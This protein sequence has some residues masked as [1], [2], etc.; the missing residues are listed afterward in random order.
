MTRK[1]RL[2]LLALA[3]LLVAMI[4]LVV[5]GLLAAKPLARSAV[6]KGAR[7]LGVEVN[8][9]YVDVG[10]GWVRLRE[11]DLALEGVPGL[12]ATIE[13]ATVDLDG[14]TP[15][16]VEARGVSVSM[17]GSAADFVVNLG[18]WAKRHPDAVKFPLVADSVSAV[19]RENAS[20]DPWLT[21]GGALVAPL[22]GG[23]RLTAE[24]ATVLGVSVGP[25]GAMWAADNAAVTFGFGNP[26]PAT[27]L[28]RMDVDRATGTAKVS[29]RPVKLSALAQ[30]LGVRLPIDGN[31][32]VEG[33]ATLS[34]D[35]PKGTTE[36][37]GTLQ[38][39][40]RGY[41]PPHPRELDGIVFGDV[42]TF[43]T[44]FRI[45]GDRKTV[46]LA[47]SRVAAGAFV[48]NG[49]GTT[50]RAE[51]HAKI[52]MNMAGDIP[53]TSLAKSAAVSRLGGALGQ[54]LGD[55]AK[56]TL[57][58]AVRVGVKIEADSRKLDEAKVTHD[59]SIGCTLRFP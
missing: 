6:V 45:S 57:A 26:D 13:R 53:C 30:P 54:L 24:L 19:W 22:P 31:V 11:T 40:L 1:K 44:A 28:V 39:K 55:A 17:T 33:S 29:L 37:E 15:V 34:L 32:V 46:H 48:L 50:E 20:E 2:V 42:T 3:G 43:E 14:L 52:A 47:K 23:S 5:A 56:R 35:P 10:W 21:V 27:A 41:V 7:G 12:R 59:V 9:K 4:G 16:R 18:S 8:P 49:T 25:V 51:D 38:A 58:G 36:V